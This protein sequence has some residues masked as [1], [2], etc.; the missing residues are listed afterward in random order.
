MFHY[1]LNPGSPPP[2][3]PQAY[4]VEIKMEDAALKHK[5]AV[6]ISASKESAQTLLKLDEEV[7]HF[8]LLK[9]FIDNFSLWLDLDPRPVIAE[10]LHEENIP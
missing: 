10:L 3:R 6:T 9:V 1:V 5:M 8:T 7:I 2:D 4:D